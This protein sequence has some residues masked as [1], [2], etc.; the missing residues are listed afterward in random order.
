MMHDRKLKRRSNSALKLSKKYMDSMLKRRSVSVSM[1]KKNPNKEQLDSTLDLNVCA[2]KQRKCSLDLM[3]K[4]W[5]VNRLHIRNL[6]RKNS[7]TFKPSKEQLDSKPKMRRSTSVSMP[8]KN[9][10][11]QRL[12]MK[13]ICESLLKKKLLHSRSLRRRSVFT[14]KLKKLLGRRPR[15]RSISAFELCKKK[16]KS[17]LKRKSIYKT[18]KKKGRV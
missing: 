12:D 5:S 15:R 1:L 7:F 11:G 10:C 9:I 8:K 6:K 14:F 18:P 16:Q 17:E 2:L 3:P 13:S 4:R